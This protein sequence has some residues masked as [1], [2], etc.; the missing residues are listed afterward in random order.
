MEDI[1]A[2]YDR[3]RAAGVRFA[4]DAPVAI[5][6]GRHKGGYTVYARDPDG[7]TIELIQLPPGMP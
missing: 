6:A 4:S 1:H 5:L 7:V 3:L 2:I